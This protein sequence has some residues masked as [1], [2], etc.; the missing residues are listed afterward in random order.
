MI[1]VPNI[2]HVMLYIYILLWNHL[3]SGFFFVF[4]SSPW[5]RCIHSETFS[6]VLTGEDGSRW[7]CYCRKI[8]VS[9]DV[10]AS[11]SLAGVLMCLCVWWNG[12]QPCAY[13]TSLRT[14]TCESQTIN[15]L[16]INDRDQEEFHHFSL[17][18]A[19]QGVLAFFFKNMAVLS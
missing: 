3:D 19:S 10:F 12:R 7:F 5:F 4:E 11:E 15:H 14:S 13:S 8:L 16:W 18:F 1:D 6:F 2:N 9:V 17:S